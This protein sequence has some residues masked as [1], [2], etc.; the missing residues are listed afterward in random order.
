MADNLVHLSLVVPWHHL[1]RLI[2]CDVGR[3][4]TIDDLPDDDLLIK[5]DFYVFKYQGQLVNFGPL[6]LFRAWLRR[7]PYCTL[8]YGALAMFA[9]ADH[10]GRAGFSARYTVQ[11]IELETCVEQR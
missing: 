1:P 10:A 6:V 2:R 3:V 4:L 11:V 8:R 9:W 5:F 7:D